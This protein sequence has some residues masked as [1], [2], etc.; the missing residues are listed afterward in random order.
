MQTLTPQRGLQATKRAAALWH[1]VHGG[2][3]LLC[4]LMIGVIAIGV[5][6]NAA[7]ATRAKGLARQG[8]SSRDHVASLVSAGQEMYAMARNGAGVYKATRQDSWERIKDD[9]QQI[10]GGRAGLF[11]VL[12]GKGDIARYTEGMRPGQ[13]K[14]ETVG[15]PGAEFAVTNDTLY[16]LS[17][18]R[19]SLHQWT[20]KTGWVT[21]KLPVEGRIER[22]Y[23]GGAGLFAVLPGG[24]EIA[25]YA[26]STWQTV[27]G[28]GLEF[29]VTST[30]LYR[31]S[32]DQSV[33]EW[34]PENGWQNIADK[35]QHIY[36]GGETPLAIAPG[37]GDVMQFDTNT[38]QWT[39]VGG[40]GASFTGTSDGRIFG[41]WP[42][43]SGVSRRGLLG[44]WFGM[45]KLTDPRPVL[46]G[47][48]K[49]RRLNELTEPG[50]KA[51]AA[52][53]WAQSSHLTGEIDPYG[54]RWENTEC[55]VIGDSLHKFGIEFKSA[56][57]RHDI[58]Y[59]GYRDALG[60]EGFRNGVV[61]VTGVGTGS[62]KNRVDAA[63][64]QDLYRA[65][66]HGPKSSSRYGGP[67]KPPGYDWTC[68]QAA[69]KVWLAVA[70]LG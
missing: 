21:V 17:L 69:D 30:A 26:D 14:W 45:P 58:G 68:R 44:D 8:V 1:R 34:T 55:N 10:Y 23:G 61:G 60:E 37:H 47:E 18:D 13:G 20:E 16:G 51:T 65:C 49:V 5:T 19:T 56:C 11:A 9:V 54:F 62:P 7:P 50:D 32:A 70:S 12:P 39:V 15:G 38:R 28:A 27:G 6:A 40:P 59:R 31:L 36:G 48:Q 25:R 2:I 53:L 24:K 63:F 46:P 29:A 33:A 43:S 42:D 22:I 41:I 52:W 4:L 57:A 3:R 66:D 35:M 67:L 64:K